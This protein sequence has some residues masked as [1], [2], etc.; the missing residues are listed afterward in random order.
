MS[1]EGGPLSHS[2]A[3]VC[4]CALGGPCA[5]CAPAPKLPAAPVCQHQLPPDYDPELPAL[6]VKCSGYIAPTAAR[7]V[8]E[9][10]ARKGDWM[11]T[12]SGRQYWPL[13]PRAADV[14]IRDICEHLL[15]MCRYCGAC[16]R[17]YSVL[18]HSLGALYV[19]RAWIA[20]GGIWFHDTEQGR[21]ARRNWL[22]AVFAHDFAEAYCHDL[23]RP[24]KYCISGYKEVEQ[25]NED[26]IARA[27]KIRSV[28]P[29]RRDIKEID[30]AMLLAE[31]AAIMLKPPEKWAP[32][33]VAEEMR[34]A[35]DRY[36]KLQR[37]LPWRRSRWW[38]RREF[39]RQFRELQAAA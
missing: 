4:T 5:M 19:A 25:D 26:A 27:L 36:M 29:R 20:A 7:P 14:D 31:Q 34:A 3:D 39:M 24:I 22:L 1:G 12:Y 23:I 9:S 38:L 28:G 11:Q 8:R 30:H 6:C 33:V 15:N 37:W 21:D 18:E 35:A 16:R 2:I 17:F 32:I 13:D 10:T